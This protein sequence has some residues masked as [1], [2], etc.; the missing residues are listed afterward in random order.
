MN[1]IESNRFE[2]DD[3][4]NSTKSIQ[5]VRHNINRVNKPDV[6]KSSE[7]ASIVYLGSFVAGRGRSV[8][9]NKVLKGKLRRG[10][11]GAGNKH[12]VSCIR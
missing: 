9:A 2:S 10:Y 7:G 4:S 8:P 3:D 6:G 11:V 1:R 5:A 12:Y